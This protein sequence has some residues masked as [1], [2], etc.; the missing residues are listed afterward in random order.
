MV[1]AG[2]EGVGGVDPNIMFVACHVNAYDVFS[3]TMQRRGL[4]VEED[5]FSDF[6][7]AIKRCYLFCGT[8]Y[9][10]RLGS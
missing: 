6:L 1:S 8:V 4:G 10:N 7:M 5:V 2:S 9:K 3:L